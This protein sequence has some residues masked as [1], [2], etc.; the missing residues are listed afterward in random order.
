MMIVPLGPD[1]VA[2]L[3]V[4]NSEAGLVGGTYTFAAAIAGIFGSFFLDRFDRKKA[5][6]FS[7]VGLS[8]GTLLGGIANSFAFLIATRVVAGLFGGPATSLALSIVSDVVPAERRGK[9]MG[10]VMGAFTIASIF[11]VPLGLELARI[12]G[13][14][15]PFLFLGVAIFASAFFALKWLPSLR[16]HLS[17]RPTEFSFKFFNKNVLLALCAVGFSLFGSFLII[18][19]FSAYFQFNLGFQRTQ[20]GALYF[21]GGVLSFLGMQLAGRSADRFGSFKVSL[22]SSILIGFF[23]VFGYFMFP[24]PLSPWVIFVGYMMFTSA[25]GVS[26]TSLSSAVPS[27]RERARFMSIQSAIQH[28]ASAVGAFGAAKILS[29]GESGALVG[30]PTVAAISAVFVVS[31]PLF[32]YAL[33]KNMG[34]RSRSAHPKAAA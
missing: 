9:A 8:V 31:V 27:S 5:L 19:N 32:V 1:L 20:L 28:I 25:R 3:G 29:T 21:V 15:L 12:G 16:E 10:S 22:V 26:I 2:S 14:R 13:W 18:P 11:G 6:L 4:K 33:E 17:G 23:T 24:S 34:R 30:M 7:I